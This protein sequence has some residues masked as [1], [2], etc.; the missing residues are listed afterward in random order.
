MKYIMCLFTLSAT[1]ELSR[2]PVNGSSPK[3]LSKPT[4]VYCNYTDEILIFGGQEIESQQYSSSIFSF[5]LQT[6]TWGEVV[7]GS[8]FRP[9]GLIFAQAFMQSY[10]KMIVMFGTTVNEISSKCFSFDLDAK[11]WQLEELKGDK[12]YG[13]IASA[14]CEF[15]Y[16]YV[17]YLAVYGGVTINGESDELFLYEGGC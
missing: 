6:F 13:R 11:T 3:G 12:V 1:F 2:V 8:D 4:A 7:Y 15:E 10:N 16:N 14:Y 5:N 9:P 17:K